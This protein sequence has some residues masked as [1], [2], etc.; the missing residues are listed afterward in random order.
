MRPRELQTSDEAFPF[1]VSWLLGLYAEGETPQIH[2]HTTKLD[3]G[4]NKHNSYII[5]NSV[6]SEFNN[7][8][9]HFGAKISQSTK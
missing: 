4:R 7:E 9:I 5:I 2:T 1:S 8:R 6:I 3:G